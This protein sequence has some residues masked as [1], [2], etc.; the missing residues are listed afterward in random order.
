MAAIAPP[1]LKSKGVLWTRKAIAWLHNLGTT[2]FP[3]KFVK[4]RGQ[5]AKFQWVTAANFPMKLIFYGPCNTF[6]TQFSHLTRLC[7]TW[8]VFCMCSRCRCGYL[9]WGTSR[10]WH[11]TADHIWLESNV[12]GYFGKLKINILTFIPESNQTRISLKYLSVTPDIFAKYQISFTTTRHIMAV[13]YASGSCINTGHAHLRIIL[14]G[15]HE[16]HGLMM[17]GWAGSVY[18]VIVRHVTWLNEWHFQF[19]TCQIRMHDITNICT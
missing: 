18:H 1:G 5:F 11:K 19:V 2:V 7:P 14:H 15:R 17:H 13:L 16:K 6:V 8:K 3:G 12:A 9:N 10:T 4:F